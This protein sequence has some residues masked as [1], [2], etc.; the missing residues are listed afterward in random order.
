MLLHKMQNIQSEVKNNY[1]YILVLGLILITA[2]SR[3]I[4]HLPNFTPILAVALFLG[5]HNNNK[6]FSYLIPISILF[7]TDLYI[8][9]YSTLP[10]VYL[11]VISVVMLG[12]MNKTKSNKFTLVNVLLSSLLFFVVTNIGVWY[13][14]GLYK[15]NIEGLINCFINAIPFYRN[16]LLSN[17]IF[18]TV[19]F[20]G[21]YLIDNK[22]KN[23]QTT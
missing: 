22:I 4:P 12:S 10:F 3:L 6:L 9:F 15:M 17:I 18:S 8:G 16:E 5:T 23:Y 20:G 14:D 13:V 7:I 1:N 19:I 21:K 2:I 11:S